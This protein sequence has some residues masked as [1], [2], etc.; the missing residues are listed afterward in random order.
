MF[1]RTETH[2]KSET[3]TKTE[4]EAAHLDLFPSLDRAA[5][6]EALGRGVRSDRGRG[7]ADFLD[8]SDHE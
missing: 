1:L 6:T 4:T 8:M 3:E 2:L 5:K 7:N